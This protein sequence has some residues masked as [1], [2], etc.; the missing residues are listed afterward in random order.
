MKLKFISG[1]TD[2]LIQRGPSAESVTRSVEAFLRTRLKFASLPLPLFYQAY[3]SI[4]L[5]Y[6]K[7]NA[8]TT[9]AT[10]GVLETVSGKCKKQ[11]INNRK[12][13]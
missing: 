8:T 1:V 2:L 9:L 6:S 7:I 10:Q 12:M 11:N 13:R 3:A 5:L 4:R